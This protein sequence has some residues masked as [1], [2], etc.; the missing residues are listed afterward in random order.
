MSEYR[1]L[2][3]LKAGVKALSHRLN[4]S[5]QM[6]LDLAL[7]QSPLFSK[8]KTT[9][10]LKQMLLTDKLQLKASNKIINDTRTE[11]CGCCRIIDQSAISKCYYCDQ[12]L[13]SSC[14][15]A[16]VHCSELFCQNCS[17]PVYNRE[18]QNMCLNCYR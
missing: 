13:C 10:N 12:T 18:E 16:C 15:S 2:N 8:S 14:L 1:T 3:M 4:T 6:D 17:L 9:S 5:T 7:P 11:L